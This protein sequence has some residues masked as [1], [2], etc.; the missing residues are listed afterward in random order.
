VDFFGHNDSFILPFQTSNFHYQSISPP[1][2]I[3][4]KEVSREAEKKRLCYNPQE[5]N[6][7]HQENK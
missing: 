3:I 1:K 6:F 7:N 4:N 5:L 2:N